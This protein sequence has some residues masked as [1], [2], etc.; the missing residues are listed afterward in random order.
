MLDDHMKLLTQFLEDLLVNDQFT[1]LLPW[2]LAVT[3][4]PIFCSLMIDGTKQIKLSK[5]NTLNNRI[6]V[7]KMT[8]LIKTPG[9]KSKLSLTICNKSGS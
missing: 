6:K 4:V 3:K 9:R 1:R 8:Y 7:N 2:E 5:H